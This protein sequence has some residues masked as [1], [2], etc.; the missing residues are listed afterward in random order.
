MVSAR[1]IFRREYTGINVDGACKWSDPFAIKRVEEGGMNDTAKQQP[2]LW[3]PRIE[4]IVDSAYTFQA[5]GL[6]IG[7]GGSDG[8]MRGRK[9]RGDVSS[10][11]LAKQSI[12][13]HQSRALTNWDHLQ[14]VQ[15]VDFSLTLCSLSGFKPVFRASEDIHMIDP[16]KLVSQFG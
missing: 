6:A 11:E 9:T 2:V 4:E 12:N 5:R 10:R 3:R 1:W 15:I 8:G 13:M 16:C 14:T 7:G